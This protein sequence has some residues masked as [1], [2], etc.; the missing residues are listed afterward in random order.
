LLQL[1]DLT[2]AGYM[3]KNSLKILPPFRVQVK[4]N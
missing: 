1:T 2:Q 3:V 4:Q